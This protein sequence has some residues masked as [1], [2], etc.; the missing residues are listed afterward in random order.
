MRRLLMAL[1]IIS[2]YNIKYDP[3][4]FP[5]A[6]PDQIYEN[7]AGTARPSAPVSV[8]CQSGESPLQARALR[9]VIECNCAAAR[10]GGKQQEVND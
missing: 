3:A 2:A 7:M 9:P 1:D 8:H 4:P 5:G 10:R 6:E